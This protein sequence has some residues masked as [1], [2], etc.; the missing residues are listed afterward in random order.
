MQLQ[1][2]DKNKIQY[3]QGRRSR[4]QGAMPSNFYE[5]VGFSEILMHRRKIF[6]LLLLLRT[7]VS[8]FIGKSL[9]LAL[10]APRRPL[11]QQCA[12]L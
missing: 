10:Q 8:N 4:G 3:N 11:I 5:I 12:L 2:K 6:G 7:K 1:L 9:N